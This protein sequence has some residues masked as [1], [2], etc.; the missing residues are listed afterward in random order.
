MKA[1][2]HPQEVT[3][4][5]QLMGLPAIKKEIYYAATG[6]EAMAQLRKDR[7][8]VTVIGAGRLFS[9]LSKS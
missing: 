7:P 4:I 2:I 3:Y 8:D 5:E 1:N 9:E 6:Q